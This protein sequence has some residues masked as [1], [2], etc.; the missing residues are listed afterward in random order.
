MQTKGYF[1]LKI[2]LF[3]RISVTVKHQKVNNKQKNRLLCKSV[4]KKLNDHTVKNFQMVKLCQ[5]VT[6][7]K[8]SPYS[9]LFWSELFPDFP[10]FG[11]NTERFCPNARKSGKNADQKN[12]EYG[13]FLCSVSLCKNFEYLSHKGLFSLIR[14]FEKVIL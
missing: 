2:T 7:R 9:E 1:I 6:R 11:L 4:K 3:N 10:A 13:L 8:K 5:I 14:L 12:S